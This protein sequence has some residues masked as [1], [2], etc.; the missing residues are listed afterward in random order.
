MKKPFFLLALCLST[1]L[2][3]SCETKKSAQTA[4]ATTSQTP[5]S[6]HSAGSMAGMN[7][8]QTH[9]D[10]QATGMMAVMNSMMHDM[11]AF[12]P[13]GNTDHDFAHMMMAHHQGAVDMSALELREG[14]DA[15][16]RAM[17]GKIS[18][19]Q[20]REIKE[21][22][23][24]ATRLDGAPTNYKPADPADPFTTQM[25][26]S[27]DGMMNMGEPTGNVD[28]DY[29][30][31]MVPHHQSAVDMAKAEVA[32]GRDTKLK[33]MAQMMIDAQQE[34]IQQ[35]KAWQAKNGGKPQGAA[36]LYECPM[37][38][39]GSQSTTPGKCPT[40]EMPLEKKA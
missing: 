28:Q 1:G 20:Q 17:A 30:L 21:L 5:T 25:K 33:E 26:S 16:L 22:Q 10:A 19:D 38:C 23:A 4:T 40:C 37:G 7:H 34:E 31:M 3:S 39:E 27:M 9:H 35:F 24:I 18:A 36:A 12:K 29:A 11:E 2:M 32:H 14:Q 6:A 8:S 13:A 15:T